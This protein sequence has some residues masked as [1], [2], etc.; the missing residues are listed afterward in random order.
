M[1]DIHRVLKR[2][3]SFGQRCVYRVNG[4]REG[5]EVDL[6]ASTCG[7]KGGVG[8]GDAKGLLLDLEKRFVCL[9]DG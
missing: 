3:Q 2:L 4:R 8:D 7:R 9:R 6:P 1:E 5:L